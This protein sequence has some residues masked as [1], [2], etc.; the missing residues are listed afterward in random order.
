MYITAGVGGCI[1]Q[2]VWEGVNSRCRRVYA[3][4]GVGGCIPQL[5]C[6]GYAPA[7]GQHG[8]A[9]GGGVGPLAEAAV[10]LPTSTSTTVYCALLP[11]CP[12]CHSLNLGYID[13]FLV[14]VGRR[15]YTPTTLSFVTCPLWCIGLWF[16]LSREPTGDIIT[17]SYKTLKSLMFM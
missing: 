15:S 14:R 6:E 3:T 2:L 11:P 16:L 4:G 13:G 7:V 10:G 9:A 17:G 12:A 5:V 1:P 8:S